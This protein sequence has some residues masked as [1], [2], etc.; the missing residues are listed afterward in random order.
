MNAITYD[1]VKL[2]ELTWSD[3][4]AYHDPVETSH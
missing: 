4:L 1:L 2:V 3:I